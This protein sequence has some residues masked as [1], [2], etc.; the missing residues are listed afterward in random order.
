MIIPYRTT[1]NQILFGVME[2]LGTTMTVVQDVITTWHYSTMITALKFGPVTPAQLSHSS[3]HN[4][5]SS[6]PPADMS[7][8][9]QS[10]S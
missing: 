4:Q 2:E 6:K 10:H 3:F 5:V 1:E 7:D 8:A 9:A